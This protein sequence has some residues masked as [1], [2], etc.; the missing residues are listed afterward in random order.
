[1][2]DDCGSG[3]RCSGG[4]LPEM[5][6]V[7]GAGGHVQ[8]QRAAL[9]P[10]RDDEFPGPVPV[11]HEGMRT[12]E[13]DQPGQPFARRDG[14]RGPEPGLQTASAKLTGKS[15]A[16]DPEG[17]E[18]PSAVAEVECGGGVETNTHGKPA[19]VAQHRSP[20]G[21]ATVQVS[22]SARPAAL[23]SNTTHG[24]GL[25][26]DRA[27][28]AKS[29]A[30]YGS[31]ANVRT[32]VPPTSSG[33]DRLKTGHGKGRLLFSRL[34]FVGMDDPKACFVAQHLS[35]AETPRTASAAG[36]VADM[37]SARQSAV[38]RSATEALA[39][40]DAD[41]RSGPRPHGSTIRSYGSDQL[42]A[43]KATRTRAGRPAPDSVPLPAG[44][45]PFLGLS[46]LAV[47]STHEW[48]TPCSTGVTARRDRHL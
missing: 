8:S 45:R 27:G 21:N 33:S 2:R 23:D 13:R 34:H 25:G 39:S 6:D 36:L 44:R 7:T 22:G 3:E 18:T 31:A 37:R 1:M 46:N 17:H 38:E 42:D 43:V 47:Y 26:N 11:Y 29:K 4:S 28:R 14:G 41:R 10:S 19:Q 20:E 35:H 9:D 30:G 15:G 32:W 12:V 48:R 16:T 24:F 5:W 40:A